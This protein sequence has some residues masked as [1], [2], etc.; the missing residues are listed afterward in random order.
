LNN[1]AVAEPEWAKALARAAREAPSE[2]GMLQS[3][4]VYRER[5]AIVNSTG[6]AI[7]R[8]GGGGDRDEGR[9]R[10][11]CLEPAEIFCP[12]AGAAAYRRAMLDAV[13]LERG[14]LDP[15]H[16]LYYEDTDLGWRCRLA[17]W[18]AWYV[19]TAIVQHVWH[20]S[21]RRHPAAWLD[22]L[23]HT[24]R[25]RTLVKNASVEL[26]ARVAP[27]RVLGATRL[28]WSARAPTSMASSALMPA[29]RSAWRARAEVE[30]L[31]RISRRELEL[32]WFR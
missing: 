4:M 2:C 1:D 26:L 28:A 10:A 25:V 11:Q 15:E 21:T 3:L 18:S 9:E 14:W 27:A 30:A 17:G 13:R 7:S 24:N 23:A 12:T 19:P 16:F 20:G 32:R 8:T 31:R 29:L 6:I 5:P 22:R